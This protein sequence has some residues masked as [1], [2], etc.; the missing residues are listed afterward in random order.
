MTDRAAVVARITA[1]IR[2]LT[3]VVPTP[4]AVLFGDKIDSMDMVEI[5]MAVE[6]EFFGDDTS[7]KLDPES[8]WTVEKIADLVIAELAK[9]EVAA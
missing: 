9:R 2:F 6:D 5:A 1:R 8:D 3:D 7:V 4:D